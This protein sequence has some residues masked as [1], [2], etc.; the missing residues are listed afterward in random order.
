MK[1]FITLASNFEGARK[2]TPTTTHMRHTQAC[3]PS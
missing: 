3:S 1:T 2:N